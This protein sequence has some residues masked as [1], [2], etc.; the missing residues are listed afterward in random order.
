MQELVDRYGV[1]LVFANVLAL[2]LGLPVPAMPTLILV[3]AGL[4]LQ[5]EVMWLPLLGVLAASVAASL[6]GD[7]VW[8]Y[9]GRRYGNRTLQSLCRLSLSRDTCMKRT[10]RFYGRFGIRILSVA[11]FIPGLS[12]VSVPLAGAMQSRL[13]PFLRYD[14]L[15]A[16]LWAA[17]GLGLGV[18]FS[19]QVETV[20]DTLSQLGTG[21]GVV[22]GI[23]LA[24]YVGWR[25]WR[26]HALMKSLEAARIEPAELDDLIRNGRA[27]VLFDIRAPGF[28]DVD[29]YVIPGAVFADERQ[30]DGVLAAYPRDGKIVIYCAC[31]DEV[32]A[33]WMAGRLRKAGFRD[34]LP[35][36]GGIDA[37]RAG[38]FGVDPLAR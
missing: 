26:R 8:F 14:G 6:I 17:L 5:P 9:A 32:S 24:A 11:K 29:P 36:R 7:S 21:A 27:P 37:W 23:A 15:G 2:S 34:V 20:I 28:R 16:T 4:A 13:P 35:L 3:G 19:R 33:A 31:P 1:L 18:V 25:W 10:E 12:M 38:G 22:I 30:L